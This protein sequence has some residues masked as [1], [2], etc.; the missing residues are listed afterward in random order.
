MNQMTAQEYLV[1]LNTHDPEYLDD[2]RDPL[3]TSKGLLLGFVL[4]IPFWGALCGLV[5]LVNKYI[6]GG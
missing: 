5:A 3:R 4:G 2:V 1:W 6:G